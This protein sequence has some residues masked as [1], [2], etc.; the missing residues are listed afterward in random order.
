[1][2]KNRTY[3]EGWYLLYKIYHLGNTLCLIG[4]KDVIRYHK[5]E[6]DILKGDVK[7]TAYNIGFAERENLR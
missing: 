7:V 1:V 3:W 6:N 2:W 4:P 5:L